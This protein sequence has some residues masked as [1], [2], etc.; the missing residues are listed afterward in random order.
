MECIIAVEINFLRNDVDKMRYGV[1]EFTFIIIFFLIFGLRLLRLFRFRW[2]Q[3]L[4]FGFDHLYIFVK[5][6]TLGDGFW[7]IGQGHNRY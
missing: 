1:P 3:F 4:N 2:H 7:K 6:F 5:D